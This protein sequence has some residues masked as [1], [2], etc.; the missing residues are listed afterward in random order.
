M[1]EQHLTERLASLGMVGSDAETALMEL[2]CRDPFFELGDPATAMERY[3]S[4]AGRAAL[5]LIA[6]RS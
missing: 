1:S 3:G 5:I 4:C 2:F 6:T